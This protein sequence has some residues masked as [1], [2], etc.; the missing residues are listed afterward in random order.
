[1]AENNVR[2]L[3]MNRISAPNLFMLG[4]KPKYGKTKFD[5]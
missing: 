4:N 1:M 3:K 5:F 2:V